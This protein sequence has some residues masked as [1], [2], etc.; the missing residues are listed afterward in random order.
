MVKQTVAKTALLWCSLLAAAPAFAVPPPAKTMYTAAMAHEQDVRT[1]L[2]A[3]D[4]MPDVLTEVRIVIAEYENLVK[5]YPTSGYSDDALWQAGTLALDAF[6]KFGQ[7]LDKT[8]GIR[9]LRKLAATYNVSRFARQVPDR[10]ARADGNGVKDPSVQKVAEESIEEKD[11]PKTA[12]RSGSPAAPARSAPPSA[13]PKTAAAD[14]PKAAA[15]E[16]PE[17]ASP[18]GARKPATGAI[19]TIK[20]IRRTPL[21]DTVRVI[22]ELDAEVAY[23]DERISDPSRVFVDLSGTRAAPELVDRTLRFESDADIVRQI[24]I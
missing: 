17:T 6:A 18:A 13:T 15:A 1:L 11:A 5:T 10:L 20:S 8:N 12:G 3:A 9:L 22:I 7:Q 2:A 4:A 19:A 16:A 24:R 14:A 21:P 23:H